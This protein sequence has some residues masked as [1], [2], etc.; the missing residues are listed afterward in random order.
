MVRVPLPITCIRG[1][2]LRHTR[3]TLLTLNLGKARRF[4]VRRAMLTREDVS[5]H[6]SSDELLA[7]YTV[8]ILILH[9]H[10]VSLSFR[11]SPKAIGNTLHFRRL[12]RNSASIESRSRFRVSLSVNNSAPEARPRYSIGIRMGKSVSNGAPMAGIGPRKRV[13]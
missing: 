7:R 3:R 4:I 1:K 8:L 9:T 12:S 10:T 5:R 13:S 2:E 6:S 11:H